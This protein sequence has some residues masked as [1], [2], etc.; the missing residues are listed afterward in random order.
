LEGVNLAQLDN[1]ENTRGLLGDLLGAKNAGV[2][3]ASMLWTPSI[4]RRE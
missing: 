1:F 2:T 4:L 3:P